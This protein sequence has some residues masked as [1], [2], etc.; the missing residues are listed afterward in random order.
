MTSDDQIMTSDD[1]GN[2]PAESDAAAMRR[3]SKVLG[4]TVTRAMVREWRGKAYPLDDGAELRRILLSQHTCPNWLVAKSP[5]APGAGPSV[6]E[7][8]YQLL[9]ERVR[10]AAAEATKKELEAGAA[11]NHWVTADEAREAGRAIAAIFRSHLLQ[12]PNQWTPILEGL[13]PPK[14]RD[15]MRGEVGRILGDVL[16]LMEERG[17]RPG[18]ID[19]LILA[20]EAQVL[21]GIPTKSDRR[22]FSQSLTLA[23]ESLKV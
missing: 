6:G 15:K 16:R 19:D 9:L 2:S 22:K 1:K 13:S 4:G 3:L 8:R 12:L 5:E 14:M 10:I 7:L 20:I 18:N 23:L 21:A 17:A 11:L